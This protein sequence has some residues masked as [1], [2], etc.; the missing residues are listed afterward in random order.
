MKLGEP[1]TSSP[2]EWKGLQPEVKEYRYEE[3]YGRFDP[4]GLARSTPSL[5]DQSALQDVFGEDA[6]GKNPRVKLRLHPWFRRWALFER[7]SDPADGGEKWACFWVCGDREGRPGWLPPD[8]DTYDKRH[9]TLRSEMGAYRTPTKKD[10]LLVKKYAD[11]RL[12][13][14]AK[15]RALQ[16]M[17]EVNTAARED[18][19][20]WA[21]KEHGALEYYGQDFVNQMN[22][23]WGA[24]QHPW[25]TSDT[26][27]FEDLKR[28]SERYETQDMGGYY[29][30]RRLGSE[31]DEARRDL[32]IIA[33]DIK[34]I[35]DREKA[36]VATAE[37][38]GMLGAIEQRIAMLAARSREAA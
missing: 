25:T 29:Y 22:E 17:D 1:D 7:V 20:L 24:C 15:E 2:R 27:R 33:G 23:K 37:E 36:L 14:S 38:R 11:R 18:K 5:E 6:R 35:T 32:A 26:N 30:R 28:H 13:P 19:K 4:D 3:I 16:A 8:L 10:F 12:L 31:E 21:D 34:P 9:E